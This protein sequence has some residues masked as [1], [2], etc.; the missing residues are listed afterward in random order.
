[1]VK[2]NILGFPDFAHST[3]LRC[4]FTASAGSIGSGGFAHTRRDRTLS[5]GLFPRSL[6]QYPV[7]ISRTNGAAQCFARPGERE[8]PHE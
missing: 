8:C 6:V 7:A 2:T 4:D 3:H 1:M 5:G